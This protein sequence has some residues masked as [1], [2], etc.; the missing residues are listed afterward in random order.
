MKHSSEGGKGMK[1]L[2]IMWKKIICAVIAAAVLFTGIFTPAQ[3]TQA[4]VYSWMRTAKTMYLNRTIN[5]TAKNNQKPTLMDPYYS[6]D[7]YFYVKIPARMELYLS[8]SVQG[9]SPFNFIRIYNNGGNEIGSV[10]S[11]WS[12]DR[13]SNRCYIKIKMNLNGGGYYIRQADIYRTNSE[14]HRYSVKLTGQFAS[15]VSFNGLKKA[16]SG[17][18]KLTWRRFNGVDGYE[19]YRSTSAYGGYRKV[20]TVGR[21]NTSYINRGLRRNGRYYYRIRGYKNVNGTRVYTRNS[22]TRSVRV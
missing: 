2:K 8:V 7:D 18:A 10:Y 1:N 20:A 5:G 22:T 11:G 14:K 9:T 13:S 12:Y 17:A 15:S 16:S 3:T 21:N 19:I 4:A 6:Y